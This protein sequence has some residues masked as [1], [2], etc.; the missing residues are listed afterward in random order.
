MHTHA[1]TRTHTHTERERERERERE[2]EMERP[3][4]KPVAIFSN[5]V[6]TNKLTVIVINRNMKLDNKS[7]T[8][9]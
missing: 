6:H 4:V 5:I 2:T 1:R 7:S 3:I 8:E 9:R